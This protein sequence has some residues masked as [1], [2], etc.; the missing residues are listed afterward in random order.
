MSAGEYIEAPPG[1]DCTKKDGGWGNAMNDYEYIWYGN[2]DEDKYPDD[3]CKPYYHKAAQIDN[4]K[5]NT[6]MNG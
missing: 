4:I 1:K 5:V 3:A 6:L 2:I